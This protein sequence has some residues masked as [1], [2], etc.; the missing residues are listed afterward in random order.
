MRNMMEHH[1]VNAVRVLQVRT[2]LL[3]R[4]RKQK[5]ICQESTK[6][7][8]KK[9]LHHCNCTQWTQQL[10]KSGNVSNLLK[11]MNWTIV[12]TI[13]SVLAGSSTIVTFF[14]YRKQQKRIKTAEAFEKEVNALKTTVAT[15][16]DQLT[17]YDGRLNEMQKLV[18]GK[19]AYI[20]QLS[21][22]KH[23]LEIKN[24]K[25][26]SA[27]NKAHSCP[28]CSDVSNCPVIKQKIANDDEYLKNLKNE[29]GIFN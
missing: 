26:K 16:R 8:K 20:G 7:E 3:V 14:L 11:V 6:T 2:F 10:S 19:D 25:N 23:T 28:N 12:T 4:F 21:S 27:I 18:V 15:M 13:I 17:F 24:S 5:T 1:K 22:E 9:G 29:R